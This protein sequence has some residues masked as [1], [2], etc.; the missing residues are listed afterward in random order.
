MT[1]QTDVTVIG[2]TILVTGSLR[3]DENLTVLGRVEGQ[4]N[5]SQTL[6]VAEGGIV[7]AEVNVDNA[8][9]SGILIGNL[10]AS[11]AI[12]ITASGRV[13]GD[14]RGKR[15]IL[16]PGARVNGAIQVGR[17]GKGARI[18]GQNDDALQLSGRSTAPTSLMARRQLSQQTARTQA[19]ASTQASHSGAPAQQ[20]EAAAAAGGSNASHQ[21][22]QEAMSMAVK[23]KVA[24]KKRG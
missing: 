10:T 18:E 15:L 2:E 11:D 9:V 17:A 3:G 5:L 8:I 6:L 24:G 20:Q 22:A 21:R 23:K 16:E 12:Q 1:E 4:I 14:V 19:P 13:L 7:K